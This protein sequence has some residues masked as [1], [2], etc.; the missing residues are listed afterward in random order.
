MALLDSLRNLLNRGQIAPPDPA[1]QGNLAFTPFQYVPT[2]LKLTPD[3]MLCSSAVWGCI[4]NI[5]DPIAQAPLEVYQR[6]AKGRRTLADDGLSYLLNVRPNPDQTA[7]AFKEVVLTQTLVWGN[8]YAEIVRDGAGRVAELWPLD[9][10]RMQVTRVNGRLVY[11]YAQETGEQAYLDA[12]QVLHIR[13]PSVRGL[14][15]TSVVFQAMKAIALGVA[16]ERFA[17]SFFAN[18]T[19]LGGVLKVPTMLPEAERKA[20]GLPFGVKA[21]AEGVSRAWVT[22]VQREGDQAR[23]VPA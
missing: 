17:T 12:A 4:R 16:Q 18:G 21:S 2:E 22:R 14:M 13:G 15:G 7:Q 23:V 6:D 11:V 8:G 10:E 19:V 1:R 20:L 5:V 3:E 9:S